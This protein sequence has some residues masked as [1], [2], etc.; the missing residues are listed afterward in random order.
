MKILLFAILGVMLAATV[1]TSSTDITE[2]TQLVSTNLTSDLTTD[3]I[4]ED[5]G[6]RMSCCLEV[7]GVMICSTRGG[8]FS[9]CERAF[10][11]ACGDLDDLL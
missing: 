8:L 10:A 7:Q 1:P 9:S 4:Y 5:I 3:V 2:E 6:C 11:K